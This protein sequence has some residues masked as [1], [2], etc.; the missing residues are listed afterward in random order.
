MTHRLIKKLLSVEFKAKAERV[1][2][3]LGSADDAIQHLA[4]KLFLM[5]DDE[6]TEAYWL[7]AIKNAAIDE[8]RKEAVRDK[9]EAHAA[10][11]A[12]SQQ[13]SAE[14]HLGDVQ[15]IEVI[16]KALNS[17]PVLTRQIFFIYIHKGLSQSVIASQIGISRSSV[18]KHIAKAREACFCALAKK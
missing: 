8:Q 9:Y 1:M 11:L 5:P 6:K 4:E 13:A 17:L 10:Y 16:K 12:N 18:E 7:R 14:I 2:G 15:D 3:N